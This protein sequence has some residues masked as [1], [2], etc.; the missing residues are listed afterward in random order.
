VR[1]LTRTILRRNGYHVLDAQN[2]G[3]AF[4]ICEKHTAKIDLLITDVVMP[5]MSGRELAERLEPMRPAMRVL[6]VSGYTE[7]SAIYN[8]V[9]DSGVAFLQKPSAPD[10]LLRKVREVLD[11]PRARSAYANE[12]S[13]TSA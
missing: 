10:V 9:L 11:A 5:R 7:N 3:E 13:A 6:Y 8:G 1:V 12:W 4:L 2:G